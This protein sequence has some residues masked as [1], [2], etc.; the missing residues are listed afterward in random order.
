MT[1]QPALGHRGK[2]GLAAAMLAMSCAL[3]ACSGDAADPRPTR[4]VAPPGP[5]TRPAQRTWTPNVNDDEAACRKKDPAPWRPSND[6]Y[7]GPGPHYIYA[8]EVQLDPGE[9]EHAM[10]SK[11]L[12]TIPADMQMPNER[13]PSG[14][15]LIACVYDGRPTHRSGTVSCYFDNVNKT[16][17]YPFYES[18]YEVIVREARTGKK[19]ATFSVPGRTTDKSDCPS[20]VVDTGDTIILKPLDGRTLGEK[21]RP[22]FNAPK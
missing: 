20:V 12:S 3:G 16:R 1:P 7:T 15:Q 14:W 4:T 17:K 21:L 19:V 5:P 10:D 22:L 6:P 13:V 9:P 11:D 18:R 8:I 2:G